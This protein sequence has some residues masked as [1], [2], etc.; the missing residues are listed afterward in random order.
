MYC[1]K[2]IYDY[3]SPAYRAGGPTQSLSNMVSHLRLPMG[4]IATDQDLDGTRLD[5]PA[6]QWL[7]VS[8]TSFAWYC[9]PEKRKIDA[10][11][12]PDDVLFI[13][14]IFSH[15]FD[16]PALLKSRAKRK[17]VSPR[18]ML[19]PGSLSQK[20][21][22][23][24]LYLTWW[25][26]KGLDR[27]CEWHATTQQEKENIHA[28]F[29][30]KAKVW[31]VPN[32]PRVLDGQETAK[33]QG[34][35]TMVSIAVIS[36]MK[37][38]L[39][40]LKAI[41]VMKI[42]ILWNIYGPVKDAVYWTECLSMI[43]SMPSNIRVVYHGDIPPHGVADVLKA[44]HIAVLPSKSENFGHSIFEALT[45]GKPVIT[46]HHTPWNGLEDQQS[47]KNVSVN[48]ADEITAA[49]TFFATMEEDVLR[50][51]STASREFALRSVNMEAIAEGYEQMFT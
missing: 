4:V 28:V 37:N 35:L 31:V 47:G 25:K 22:K 5:V 51:W 44:A 14:S 39:L 2:L 20:K 27:L 21:W 34:S 13:N 6:D 32:F 26:L 15:H 50:K 18:G 3:F 17:I 45:A 11:I 41:S 30:K 8:E 10:L 33:E 16:Y 7:Q 29:G 1:I 19:D 23:K 42:N 38:H 48:D 43:Q 9:S 12:G 24:R 40:V 46:S 36:P 49:I